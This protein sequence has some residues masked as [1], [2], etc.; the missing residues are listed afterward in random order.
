MP[1]FDA[2]MGWV[3]SA[4]RLANKPYRQSAGF[5]QNA[6]QFSETEK[7]QFPDFQTENRTK[8]T[9]SLAPRTGFEP[10]AYR[11]G[12][13]RSI[14]L[15]YRGLF[16]CMHWVR[17]LGE[18]FLLPLRRQS[19]YPPKLPTNHTLTFSS[20]SARAD[21]NPVTHYTQT[22]GI[23]QF[24]RQPFSLPAAGHT[25]APWPDPAAPPNRSSSFPTQW[26]AGR[27][28]HPASG[29]PR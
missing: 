10:A 2:L 6:N 25:T 7:R 16:T 4:N 3:R 5:I 23:C 11:L 17:G 9:L 24:P 12:G 28:P 15:S 19:L 14:H 20:C 1:L 26:A 21:N 27:W 13:G 22:N 18:A 8:L 29:A